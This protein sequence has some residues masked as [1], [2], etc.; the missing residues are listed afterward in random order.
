MNRS[1]QLFNLC[2]IRHAKRG[3]MKF[4]V[5][6]SAAFLYLLT[7][8]FLKSVHFHLNP[9]NSES[10]LQTPHKQK[11]GSVKHNWLNQCTSKTIASAIF[12]G[13]TNQVAMKPALFAVF[14]LLSG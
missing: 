2:M 8:F 3:T 12:A 10:S 1:F 5:L 11:M 9:R 14:V 13:L 4:A 6:L 7:F